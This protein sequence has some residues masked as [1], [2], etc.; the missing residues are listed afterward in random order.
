M[1][2]EYLRI[3]VEALEDK[4]K[5]LLEEIADLEKKL[6]SKQQKGMMKGE[7]KCKKDENEELKRICTMNETKMKEE[8]QKQLNVKCNYD[9]RIEM[10][11]QTFKTKTKK[12]VDYL[13]QKQQAST[14]TLLTQTQ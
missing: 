1:I 11:N 10:L 2:G 6:N 7:L 12:L 3:E 14:H 9:E 4:M 13:N 5:Q 8:E